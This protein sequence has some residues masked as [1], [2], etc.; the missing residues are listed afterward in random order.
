VYFFDLT[1]EQCPSPTRAFL[2]TQTLKGF[3]LYIMMQL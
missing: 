1:C 3:C 2:V